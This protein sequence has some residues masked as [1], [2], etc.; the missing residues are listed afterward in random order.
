MIKILAQKN[1]VAVRFAGQQNPNCVKMYNQLT[2][3]KKN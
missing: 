3:L 1:D 2:K